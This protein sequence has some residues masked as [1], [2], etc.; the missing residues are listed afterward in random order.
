MHFPPNNNKE[1]MRRL[2]C[3]LF[4]LVCVAGCAGPAAP[5]ASPTASPAPVP[6]ATAT[7]SP[8]EIPTATPIP[9]ATA[10]RTPP[11]LPDVFQTA[12]QNPVDPPHTYLANTCQYL[13]DKWSSNNSA[14]GTVVIPVMFHS[15]M[16]PDDT[17]GANQISQAQFTRSG[18]SWF[19]GHHY[20]AIGRLPG[21]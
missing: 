17:V 12:L 15:I 13:Q 18:E 2:L 14:P 8:T 9:T 6:S 1:T 20:G 16:A 7:L 11:A 3:L 4:M 10:I 19:Q 5:L 21:A